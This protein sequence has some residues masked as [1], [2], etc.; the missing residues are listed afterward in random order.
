MSLLISTWIK[1]FF[2]F[3][4]FF[5]LSMFLALT[6]GESAE[7]RKKVA[8]KAII[9]AISIA[10]ILLFFGGALFKVL[11]ITLDSFRIGSGILLF[12]SAL[13][14]VKD[15]TR[16]HV[17]G[18]MPNEERDDISVVP[19]AVPTII[20]PATIGTILVYGADFKGWDLIIGLTGLLLALAT[21]LVILYSGSLIEKLLGRT[22]L[23]ILSKITGLILA[24]MA[25]QIFMSGVMG[26]LAPVDVT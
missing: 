12:M 11:G 4:P 1:F 26:F 17:T 9:A 10:I 2:L 24:A 14:L 15:G 8:N 18:G 19:L 25:A 7:A 22:G 13:S 3:A 16:N 21:L 5:V 20:G 23:N 6:R